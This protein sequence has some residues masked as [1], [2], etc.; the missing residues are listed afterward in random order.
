MAEDDTLTDISI[1]GESNDE[2]KLMKILLRDQRMC[3]EE[4]R[5][6]TFVDWPF[7]EPAKC[8]ADAVT[9]TTYTYFSTTLLSLVLRSSM[10][11][12]P[13]VV[14]QFLAIS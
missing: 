2:E 11:V 12:V 7:S 14:D 5:R 6:N 3:F 10:K 9:T 13:L 8:T 4:N 1:I